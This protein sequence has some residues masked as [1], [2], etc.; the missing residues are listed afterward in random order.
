M[1]SS[2]DGAQLIQLE[3]IYDERLCFVKDNLVEYGQELK[4]ENASYKSSEI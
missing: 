1:R 2:L 4:W 3:V